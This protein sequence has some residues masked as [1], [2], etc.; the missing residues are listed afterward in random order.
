MVALVI[1]AHLPH[2]PTWLLN[3]TLTPSS[4]LSAQINA[5]SKPM[6]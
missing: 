1:Q 6:V 5:L 3:L 2:Q 4:Q